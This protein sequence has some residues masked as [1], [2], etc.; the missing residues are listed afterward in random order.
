MDVWLS[1]LKDIYCIVNR[2]Q[3]VG[4]SS[5]FPPCPRDWTLFIR[6]GSIPSPICWVILPAL[7]FSFLRQ[8]LPRQHVAQFALALTL[9][10]GWVWTHDPPAL[11]LYRKGFLGYHFI[12]SRSNSWRFHADNGTAGFPGIRYDVIMLYKDMIAVRGPH[13]RISQKDLLVWK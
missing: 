1:S 2:R 12:M 3:F 8:N 13:Q 4:V 11:L 6:L 5:L 9:S 10:P 7:S